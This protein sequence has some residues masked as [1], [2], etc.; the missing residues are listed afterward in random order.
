MV[1]AVERVVQGPSDDPRSRLDEP[2]PAPFRRGTD[3]GADMD[4]ILENEV[5]DWWIPFVPVS[6]GFARIALRKGAMVKEGERVQ[7]RGVLL[8]PHEGLTLPDEEVP[9]EGVRAQRVPALARGVD[10]TYIRWFSRRVGVG[11]GEG[12]SGLAFDSAVRRR[13]PPG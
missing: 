10:G 1:W 6:T 4:Y 3:P 13:P 8:R 5:P 2:R 7:P 12:T 11:R 9:R